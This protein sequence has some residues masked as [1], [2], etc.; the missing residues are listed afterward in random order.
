MIMPRIYNITK[1]YY[2]NVSKDF[3]E[4]MLIKGLFKNRITGIPGFH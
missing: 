4:Q 1:D 2:T 3:G